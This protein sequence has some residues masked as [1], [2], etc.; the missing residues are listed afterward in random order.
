MVKQAFF[1]VIHEKPMRDVINPANGMLVG[2]GN[3]MPTEEGA[4][5]SLPFTSRTDDLGKTGQKAF[6]SS[7]KRIPTVLQTFRLKQEIYLIH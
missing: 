5:Q 1:F 2:E 6:G 4:G 3:G 7:E